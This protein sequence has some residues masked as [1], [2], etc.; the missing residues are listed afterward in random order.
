MRIKWIIII[1]AF[2]AAGWLILV[3]ALDPVVHFDNYTKNADIAVGDTLSLMNRPDW[4]QYWYDRALAITPGDQDVQKKKGEVYLK[5]GKVREAEQIF[6]SVLNINQNDT[7]ALLRKGDILLQDGNFTGAI[8]YYDN[9]LAANP[10]DANTLV[11]K[12]DALLYLSID[13]QSGL[14]RYA[15]NISQYSRSGEN[16]PIA[17]YEGLR[18]M[19]SY[20]ESIDCYQKAMQIDPKLSVFISGRILSATMNQVNEYQNILNDLQAQR[21]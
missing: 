10:S 13:Q 6:D 16:T 8:E 21:P 20:R 7:A 15:R 17:S 9:V 11:R 3:P 4:A 5:T 12:G 1:V 18:A 14:R 19:D 2:L